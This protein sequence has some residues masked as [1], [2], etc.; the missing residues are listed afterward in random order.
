MNKYKT[1]LILGALF[2]LLSNGISII[3]PKIIQHAVDYLEDDVEINQLLIYAGT[4]VTVSVLFGFFRFLTRRTIIVVSRLIENDLRNDLF[5]QLQNQSD[6]F[7]QRNSTGDIMARLTN[8]LN[9]VRSV[10][11][12]GLMYTFNTITMFSFVLFMMI[13]ISPLLTL[14]AM[15]PAPALAI[16]VNRVGHK[17]NK[18]FN[19]VQVQ[20]SK[21]S[22]KAQE[23]LAGIR[24][25]KSY[26][27]EDSETDSFNFLNK[28]YIRK[29]MNYVRVY[30]AFRPMMMLIVGV[31]I[32]II[33]L[34]GGRMIT[35]GV[36]TLGEFVAFDLYLSMLVWPSI[37]LGWVMNIFYQGVASMKRMEFILFAEPDIKD[38]DNII[39][40]NKINGSISFKNL[41]FYYPNNGINVLT[42]INLKIETGKILAIVGKTGTGKSTLIKLITRIYNP[43]ENSVFIDKTDIID[44]PLKTL[45]NHIGYIPQESFLFSDTIKENIAF[46]QA[47]ISNEKI[48]WAAQMA[49]IHDSIMAF[50]DQYDT[51]LGERGINL[52]GGQKQ[53]I[54]IAR[55]LIRDPNILILD[56]ALSA[57]DTITEELILNNLR[58]IMK[59]K[60][61]IWISH[62]VSAIKYAD[63]IIMMDDGKIVEQGTHS[64]LLLMN[65]SYAQMYE[66]QQIEESIDQVD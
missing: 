46:S 30:A 29:N 9:A 22:T 21:I 31:G 38:A 6:A 65:G 50:P 3:N 37:A 64:E 15:I 40:I 32:A 58:E 57:V 18:R 54:A 34:F 56:D 7:Y 53:R 44:I 2:L 59:G 48:H 14:L 41:S 1:Q 5:S 61:C 42:N 62:R 12:P 43:P 20:F 66:K 33:L 11:G 28:E 27:Q 25:V 4:V 60:T 45:R 51:V 55:A 8:D 39:P 16:V 23:N 19:D 47:D 49:E 13:K 52:S 35:N 36:I 10:L 26:V 63:H 24:I 17:I